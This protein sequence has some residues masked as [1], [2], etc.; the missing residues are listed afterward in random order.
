VL[1]VVKNGE[2][3]MIFDVDSEV[4]DDFDQVDQWFLREV[5]E[6]VSKL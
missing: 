4:L 3:T 2:V 5:V 6:I 1:P